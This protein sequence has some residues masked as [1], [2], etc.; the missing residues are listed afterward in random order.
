MLLGLDDAA[1]HIGPP[2]AHL[3]VHGARLARA[4]GAGAAGRQL[5]LAVALALQC[6]LA[7][8]GGL[9]F[10][11]IAMRAAQV[12]QQRDFVFIADRRIRVACIQ[13]GLAQLSQQALYR[14]AYRIRVF[15][16]CY[17]CHTYSPRADTRAAHW[18]RITAGNALPANEASVV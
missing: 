12:L 13:P 1:L 9:F 10:A 15:S 11:I 14:N 16:Y 8:T 2:L 6:D 18:M 17:F 5:D 7:R 4:A 3:D